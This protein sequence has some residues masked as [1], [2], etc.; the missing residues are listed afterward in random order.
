MA[1]NGQNGNPEHWRALYRA[2]SH[3]ASSDKLPQ[4]IRDAE[5]AIVDEIEGAG[6]FQMHHQPLLDAL[7][8]LLDLEK[9]SQLDGQA[10]QIKRSVE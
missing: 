6:G 3:E 7:F 2:A 10:T 1:T 5:K 9:I 4:R 8:A